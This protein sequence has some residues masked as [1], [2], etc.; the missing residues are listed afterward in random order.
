[1]ASTPKNTHRV[2]LLGN[3]L[4]RFKDPETS[5]DPRVS[6]VVTALRTLPA[7]AVAPAP[8]PHFRAELRAQLVAVAPRIVAEA[9]TDTAPDIDTARQ[10]RPVP[11]TAA[12][13][14]RPS[15]ARQPWSFGRPLRLA[16]AALT[17]C[18]IVLGGAV[19]ASQRALPGDTLYGLKRATESARLS[20]ASSDT[21]RAKLYLGFAGTRVEEARTLVERSVTESSALSAGA[22]VSSSTAAAVR[23]TLGSSDS[24]IRAAT[25]LLTTDAVRTRSGSGLA[26]I[27][28]WAP[29][30]VSR[31]RQ[32]ATMLPSGALRHRAA[33]SS[34][35]V[36]QAA[37]RALAVGKSLDTSC[38]TRSGSDALG[39]KPCAGTS[40]GPSS[41]SHHP[42]QPGTGGP[43][44]HP[45]GTSR[46]ST[47][48][49]GGQH[50][51]SSAQRGSGAP[52]G[53]GAGG[54]GAGSSSRPSLPIPLPTN[55]S[56]PPPTLPSVSLPVSVD[57]C[58][59]SLPLGITLGNCPSS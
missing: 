46:P 25:R 58:G 59:V 22:R 37:H 42:T 10:S 35:L 51:G 7:D 21:A 39:I 5:R 18:L 33:A 26:T 57:S 1:M 19:W 3:G 43:T 9:A 55:P 32:L 48:G 23:R 12:T 53:S 44:T 6:A 41:A 13:P 27:R 45:T 47:A 54:S 30:Q 36:E 29:S 17:L 52:R 49:N 4:R 11:R 50:T 40:T 28:R 38:V 24:D 16:G 34:Q 56:L 15:R 31:L 8:Q 20:F 2:P 14:A